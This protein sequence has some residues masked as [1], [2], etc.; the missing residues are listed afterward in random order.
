VGVEVALASLIMFVGLTGYLPDIRTNAL[1][2]TVLQ[3]SGFAIAPLMT[4]IY[5]SWLDGSPASTLH[6]VLTVGAAGLLFAK[7]AILILAPGRR[8][9]PTRP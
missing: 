9:S 3:M 4:P 5:W 6:E 8:T 2:S 1:V 7:T